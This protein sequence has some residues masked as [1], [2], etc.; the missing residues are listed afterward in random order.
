MV[1][2]ATAAELYETDTTV[3]LGYDGV[4]F[5]ILKQTYYL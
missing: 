2:A 1:A 5:N 3:T 4:F